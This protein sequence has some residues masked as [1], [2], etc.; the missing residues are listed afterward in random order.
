MEFKIAAARKVSSFD[1][2]NQFGEIL[3]SADSTENMETM[4]QRSEIDVIYSV[5]EKECSETN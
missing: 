2:N 3:F 5:C 1:T 4:G